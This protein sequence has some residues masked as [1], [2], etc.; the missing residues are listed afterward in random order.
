MKHHFTTHL[1][2]G[3]LWLTLLACL[4]TS[5]LNLLVVKRKIV[6]LDSRLK[7]QTVERQLAEE[8]LAQTTIKLEATSRNLD[9]ARE[10]FAQATIEAQT[11]LE[12]ATKLAA[13]LTV[14][15]QKQ[16]DAETYLAR[17]KATRMEPEEIVQA[18]TRLK[19]LQLSLE[20]T[21]RQKANLERKL[22]LIDEQSKRD[23]EILLPANLKTKI[24]VYDP[25]WEL[26]VLDHGSEQG[27][28]QNAKLL[29][30]REGKFV[31]MLKISSV[32]KSR[33]IGNLIS[34]EQSG[35]ILEGDF[36]IPAHPG[37]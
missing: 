9:A 24:V 35:H 17:Y 36:A 6:G 7:Q 13:A 32:Q 31:G 16:D 30:G 29:V 25:K 5:C 4:T 21:Q 10:S 22:K 23:D 34:G 3:C 14:S 1:I 20:D 12:R 18:Y 15:R 37:L 11:H 8:R 27:L 33:S 2:R 28:V 26:V 19:T